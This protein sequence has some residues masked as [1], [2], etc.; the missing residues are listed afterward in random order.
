[1]AVLKRRTRMVNFR[2]SEEEYEYLK[3]MCLSEGA[4]S[5]SDLAR[6]IL[7]RNVSAQGALVHEPLNARVHELGGKVEELDRVVRRL[8][9][10]VEAELRPAREAVGSR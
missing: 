8:A 6:A 1:M 5:I 3:R 7:C 10:L 9:T 4:R 2:L